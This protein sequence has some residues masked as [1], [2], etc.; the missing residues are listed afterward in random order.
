[1]AMMEGEKFDG[2]GTRFTLTADNYVE[3]MLAIQA[4]AGHS[5][6]IL[7]KW[8]GKQKLSEQPRQGDV[9]TISLDEPIQKIIMTRD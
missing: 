9:V 8:Q 5:W 7:F 2:R 3:V 6:D 4:A 1:M